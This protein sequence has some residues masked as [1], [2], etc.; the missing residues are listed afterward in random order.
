MKPLQ[1]YI[2]S[3]QTSDD[4]FEIEPCFKLKL[5]LLNLSIK[6]RK[7]KRILLIDTLVDYI[8][9]NSSTKKKFKIQTEI[10]DTEKEIYILMVKKKHI[11]QIILEGL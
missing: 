8:T 7:E 2:S 3:P 4:E 9:A 11:I 1:K 6:K 10:E 5:K